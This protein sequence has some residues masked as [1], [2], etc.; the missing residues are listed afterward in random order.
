MGTRQLPDSP[1]SINR[2][3]CLA[4]YG[5]C[6]FSFWATNKEKLPGSEELVTRH[7]AAP[8]TELRGMQLCLDLSDNALSEQTDTAATY[9]SIV[10]QKLHMHAFQRKAAYY[11]SKNKQM[12]IIL[13]NPG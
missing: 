4:I 2:A 9:G 1:R 10:P 3:L 5:P 11:V 12:H 13:S 6:V 7:D 8:K